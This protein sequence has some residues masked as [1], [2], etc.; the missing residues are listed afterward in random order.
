[1]KIGDFGTKGGIWGVWGE[2]WGFWEFWHQ[3]TRRGGRLIRKAAKKSDLDPKIEEF[4]GK[5]RDLGG[6]KNGILEGE[7][8][9]FKRGKRVLRA[10]QSGPH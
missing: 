5:I 2:N 10:G 9:E 8:S 1:M 4:W 3:K 6:K 7:N